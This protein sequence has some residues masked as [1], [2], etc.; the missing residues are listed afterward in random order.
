[1]SADT[2]APP[3]PWLDIAMSTAALEPHFRSAGTT[4]CAAGQLT[5]AA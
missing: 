3:C 4:G 5:A 2:A 1:M